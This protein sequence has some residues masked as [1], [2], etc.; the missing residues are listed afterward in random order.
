MINNI[1]SS[2]NN[3]RILV[4]DDNPDSLLVMQLFLQLKGYSVQT[5]LNGPDALQLAQTDPP[6]VILLDIS[7]PGMDGYEVCRHLRQQ[8]GG[9]QRL[10]LALTGY[11]QVEDIKRAY[12]V[13][14]DGHFVKPV[15]MEALANFLDQH[16]G[17]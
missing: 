8:P 10:V 11:G 7:M 14:F 17:S 13:G 1:P 16:S 12:E 3:H 15:D 9:V 4:V 5:S 2:V 6:G